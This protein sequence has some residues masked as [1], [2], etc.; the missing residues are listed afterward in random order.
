MLMSKQELDQLKEM[1]GS[2]WWS[3]ERS[4]VGGNK[5][6]VTLRGNAKSLFC[7]LR[8]TTLF[9]NSFRVLTTFAAIKIEIFFVLVFSNNTWVFSQARL[10]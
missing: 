3:R 4:W 10:L 7:F 8:P 5:K 9:P 6:H 2:G 1:R